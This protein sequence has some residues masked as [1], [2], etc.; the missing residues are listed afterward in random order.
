MIAG[1]LLAGILAV[2]LAGCK[3]T[4]NTK[5]ENEKPVITLGSDNYPPYNYLNEDGVPTGI[6]VELATEAFKRMGYQVEVALINWE[7]TD[8]EK[9]SALIEVRVTPQRGQGFDSIAERIYKYPEVRSVYLM[10]GAYDLMVILEGK[11]LREVSNFVSDKL[12]TLDSVLSTA[13]HFILK[14]YKDHGTAFA[15]KKEDEREMITP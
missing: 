4:D 13:T 2:T 11:T 7:K 15:V 14:K 10:S 3:N 9:V 8:I 5:E 12:S 6:D 1:I